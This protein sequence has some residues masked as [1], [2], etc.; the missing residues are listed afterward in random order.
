MNLGPQIDLTTDPRWGR[1]AGCFSE[2]A[3][4]TAEQVVAYIEGAQGEKLG[5]DSIITMIKH[6]PGSGPH[7]GGRG[8]Q[9]VYPGNNFDYHPIPWRAAF[10]AGAVTV[11]GYYSG[12]PFDHGLA[13]N[14]SRHI[15][16]D[17]LRDRM[18]FDGVVCTDWGVIGRVGPLREDLKDLPVKDRFR[19]AL[20]AGVDQFGGEADPTSIIE[21][22]KEGKVSEQRIDLAV[23]R[24]L[25]WHFEL[26]LFENPYVDPSAAPRIVRSE[27]H[28][29]RGY[30][31]QL[32]SIVLLT[33]DGTL[34]LRQ[35]RPRAYVHGIDPE[36]AARYAEVVPEPEGAEVAILRVASVVGGF[37]PGREQEE[38]STEFPPTTMDEVKAVTKTG[39]PTVVVVNLSSTLTV[40][41]REM[42]GSAK[43]TLMVFDVLDAPLLDVVFGKFKPVGKLPFELPSSMEAVRNQKED[44]PFD[45]KDPLFRFGHGLTY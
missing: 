14:Y 23:S 22:V 9:L 31:A 37:R 45:T 7:R 39:V 41:P 43:A 15:M 30:E 36:T 40:L 33:N 44:V 6:W 28:Q 12:T 11:M 10:D 2:D 26:G 35:P 29:K 42:L 4:L 20:D 25:R 18:K 13:V 27:K 21:L 34:P 5:P 32:K 3:Q 24:I 1:N 8:R 16:T 38:V 17:V 19:M